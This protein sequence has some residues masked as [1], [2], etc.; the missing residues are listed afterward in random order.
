MTRSARK[1]K[2]S[3]VLVTLLTSVNSGGFLPVQAASARRA[4]P[5]D[6]D[7]SASELRGLIEQYAADRGN[8]TRFYTAPRSPARHARLKQFYEDTLATLKKTAFDSLSSDGQ[9]DYALFQNH[10]QHELALLDAEWKQTAEMEPLLPFASTIIALEE[11]RRR[12]EPVDSP[13]TAATLTAL[14]KQIANTRKNFEAALKPEGKGESKPDSKTASPPVKRAV[15][16]RA[17]GAINA[18][19]ATLK[20]WFDYF[21]GYDPLFTWWNADPYKQT[22]AE[23]HSYAAFVREKLVGLKP[24]DKTTIIGDPVG[25]EAIL[26]E[27]KSA[28]VPCAPEELIAIAKKE[29]AWCES[30]M[31]KA[32]R[33]LG[34]GDDWHKALEHVKD[35]HVAP[36]KQPELIR[37][38]A[39]EAIA[40]LEQHDLVTIP[41]IARDTWRMEMMSPERQLVSPFFLGGETI[42]VSYPTAAMTHEQKL[43]SMRGNNIHFSRSTVFHELIPGHHLQGFMG[44]RF[45]PYRSVFNT[46]F[47]TE[48]QA[49]YWE[50]LFWD[51][52]FPKTPENRIGMLFWRMHRCA[53]VIFSLGFHLG[54]MT[55]EDCV[56]LLVERVGHELDNA[57]AEVRRSFDGSYGPIY[58]CAYFVGARQF[59]A[60]HR[61]LVESGKMTNRAFHDAILRENRI[62]VEMLR[63]ILTRQKLSRDFTSSWRFE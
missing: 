9:A 53:R 56:K 7:T 11:S 28:M 20:S 51:M 43:M 4:A 15:A 35:L 37:D 42:L 25:R 30:E 22:D 5:A 10:L 8:L 39:L 47:W 21:N 63:A 16:N 57:T 12:L 62:P 41:P 32:S 13:K 6:Y 52:G 50:M 18:L 44:A 38:L 60:L 3:L 24:D 40:F 58:Q 59:Y 49:F 14:K 48:G 61:E 2:A 19:Q 55:P 54:Q 27:L 46:P 23:L 17:V 45:K 31:V 33:E 34:Y 29:L 36:G 26:D 1:A